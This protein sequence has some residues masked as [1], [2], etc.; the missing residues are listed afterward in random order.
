MPGTLRFFGLWKFF[1]PAGPRGRGLPPG[2][3]AYPQSI[4]RVQ[5]RGAVRSWHAPGWET[6]LAGGARGSAEPGSQVCAPRGNRLRPRPGLR[7]A[8]AASSSLLPSTSPK[9]ILRRFSPSEMTSEKSLELKSISRGKHVAII[10]IIVIFNPQLVHTPSAQ[11]WKPPGAGLS[12]QSQVFGSLSAEVPVVDP[13]AP[14]V[15]KP[16]GSAV[17]YITQPRPQGP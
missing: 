6:R 14:A 16:G 1:L 17:Q 2:G 5:P 13:I 12:L 8:Q 7:R 4:F 9:V 3:G 15:S 11:S 10:T